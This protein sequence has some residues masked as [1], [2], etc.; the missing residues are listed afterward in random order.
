M[1]EAS[2]IWSKEWPTEPGWYWF[3]G[4]PFNKAKHWIRL[5]T[6]KIVQTSK[7]IALI[8]N[9]NFM[10][11]QEASDGFWTPIIIPELPKEDL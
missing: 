5:N 1:G 2:T 7:S 8:C 9:G 6:V 10:Y 3:Y 11:K 4:D